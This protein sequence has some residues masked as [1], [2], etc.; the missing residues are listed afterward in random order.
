MGDRERDE[1]RNFA[2]ERKYLLLSSFFH[3][4]LF[5]AGYQWKA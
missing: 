2:P 5:L 1:E 3:A 4:I